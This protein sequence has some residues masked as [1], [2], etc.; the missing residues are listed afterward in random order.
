MQFITSQSLPE[1]LLSD[2]KL[3]QSVIE[4]L[5]LVPRPCLAFHRY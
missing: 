5:S 2:V 3:K 4:I 1:K